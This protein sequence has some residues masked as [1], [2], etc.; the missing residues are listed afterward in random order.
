MRMR[1]LITVFLM[2]SMA[3]SLSSC[4]KSREYEKDGVKYV[5]RGD[6][7]A[8]VSIND[9]KN[10]SDLCNIFIPDKIN[11]RDVIFVG[12]NTPVSGWEIYTSL[13]KTERIY[14]PW[15]IGGFSIC[16]W[17][18]GTENDKLTYVIS[19]STNQLIAT[20]KIR[21]GAKYVIPHPLYLKVINEEFL[22]LNICSGCINL[23]D[24][25]DRFIFAN[26]AYIFNYEGNPNEGYFFIDLIEETSKLNKPP[27][28][29][30]REGYTFC[31]WYKETECI[32]EWNFGTDEVIINFDEEGNRIYEEIKLYAKWTEK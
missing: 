9:S 8:V 11:E 19:A 7:Y 27:Y 6:V 5:M 2:L 22:D 29:P 17:A 28:D 13:K 20:S 4:L 24:F 1:K 3:L 25:Q 15:C 32:N 31:G 16:E 21:N 10:S 18:S 23:E 14:F 30:K 12:N 26:I